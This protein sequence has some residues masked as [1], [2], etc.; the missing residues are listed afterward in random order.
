MSRNFLVVMLVL[1]LASANAFGAD[2]V[3]TVNDQGVG[4]TITEGQPLATEHDNVVKVNLRPATTAN[5]V[6]YD[7]TAPGT[8]RISTQLV[9]KNGVGGADATN[10]DIAITQEG[11]L[12]EA[13][14]RVFGKGNRARINQTGK[15]NR[16]FQ[17]IRGDDNGVKRQI[18]IIQSNSE[19]VARQ[20]ITGSLNEARIVQRG[21]DGWAKQI[22]NGNGND[23]RINQSVT[24]SQN[25]ALQ[26]ISGTT[27]VAIIVQADGASNSA[28]QI[29]TGLQ[30][31]A[32]TR[33]W[34]SNNV[35]HTTIAGQDNTV[36]VDQG[37]RNQ[38]GN[39]NNSLITIDDT[40]QF[41]TVNHTQTGASNSGWG[42]QPVPGHSS[43]IAEGINVINSVIVDIDV[44]QHGSLNMADVHVE[45]SHHV[46]VVLNQNGDRNRGSISIVGSEDYDATLTQTGIALTF[47]MDVV[48][49]NGGSWTHNQF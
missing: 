43:P 42:V 15:F 3:Q 19:N 47:S 37:T 20:N 33:Q 21:Y 36:K 45:D 26:D 28:T 32:R 1:A 22:I 10:N 46:N 41:V 29:L 6:S 49:A 24:T 9:N 48:G 16:A 44:D 7:Q 35:A 39:A 18:T 34:G 30:H 11:S 4:N 25:K 31:N 8:F 38:A 27:H 12:H 14:Q 40:C 17:T 23:L 2:S 13:T 5:K